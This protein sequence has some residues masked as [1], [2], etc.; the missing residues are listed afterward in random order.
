MLGSIAFVHPFWD[1]WASSILWDLRADRIEA[2]VPYPDHYEEEPL[3]PWSLTPPVNIF[4]SR[5]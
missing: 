1:F 2:H 5:N 3:D 4:I